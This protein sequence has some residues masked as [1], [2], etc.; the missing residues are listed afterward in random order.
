MDIQSVKNALNSSKLASIFPVPDTVQW[1]PRGFN[2]VYIKFD[3]SIK[4]LDRVRVG[5]AYRIRGGSQVKS[6]A[7]LIE[8][9]VQ[10]WNFELKEGFKPK[11]YLEI[12]GKLIS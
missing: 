5:T 9:T 8:K 6:Y 12:Q 7:L 1:V 10:G 4:N 3:D 11:S 2:A